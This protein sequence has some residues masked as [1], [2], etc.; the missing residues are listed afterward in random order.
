MDKKRDELFIASG[1]SIACIARMSAPM[2]HNRVTF[3][4]NYP[5]RQHAHTQTHMHTITSTHDADDDGR[6]LRIRSSFGALIG[7]CEPELM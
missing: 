4:C 3:H 7:A 5:C 1:A 6:K 2:Q